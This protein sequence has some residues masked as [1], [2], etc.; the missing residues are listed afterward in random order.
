MQELR[1]RVVVITGAGSGIGRALAVAC[2]GEGMRVV[3]S[4]IEADALEQTAA[5]VRSS[6]VECLAVPANVADRAAVERLAE[7]AYARFGAVHL[8]CNNAGV[9][10]YKPLT[11]TTDADWQWV[12]SVNLF[13]VINGVQAFLPRLLAQGGEAH[14]VNTASIVGLYV[15]PRVGLGAYTT[16]KFAIVGLSESLRDDLAPRGIGVSVLCPGPV[17]TRINAAARNRP[18]ELGGAPPAEELRSGNPQAMAPEAVAQRVLQAVRANERYII[19]H[20]DPLSRGPVEQR[21]Q[22]ILAA[23]GATATQQ[24]V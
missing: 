10:V 15:P 11:E 14:I 21:G 4:D 13:G 5:E 9:L 20:N 2:A 7:Q 17:Y 24:S 12:L 16:S 1:D 8:L 19:T 6:G 3:V 23:F 22:R 18:P